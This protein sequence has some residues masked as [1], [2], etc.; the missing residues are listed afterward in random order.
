MR[1][2]RSVIIAGLVLAMILPLKAGFIASD[3]QGTLSK[4]SPDTKIGIIVHMAERP[5]LSAFGKGNYKLKAEYLRDLARRTQKD[6]LAYLSTRGDKVEDIKTFWTMNG[7][8]LKATPDVIREIAKRDDVWAVEKDSK[9]FILGRKTSGKHPDSKSRTVEWNIA[10]IKADSVWEMGYTGQGVILGNL[11]TGVDVTHPALQGKYLGY[12][13]DG[14]NGQT[15]PYDDHGHGTH[16]MGTMVGGDGP[17]PF[18]DDIGI[19]YNAMFVAAKAFN[20]WGSGEE[21]WILACFD[22]FA[23]LVA[24][25][26]INV[27]VVSNSW[28]SS[29]NTALTFWD[30]ILTWRSL[31]IIPVF[32]SGNSGPGSGSAGTPGNFPTVIGVGATDSGDNI[33]GFSSRGPAP[34]QDPWNDSQYWGR[35]DWNLTKPDISAPGVSVR[36][37][38]PG[39]GYDS[40]DGTSMATPHVAA[41]VALMFE[42]N[43][44]LDYETIYNTLL[45]YADHPSQ[46]GS[47]PNNDYG[48][49]RLNAYRAL[50]YTPSANI[51]HDVA[52]VMILAPRGTVAAGQALT[53]MA[54][55]RN[56]GQNTETFDV[57]FEIRDEDLNLVYQSTRTVTDLEPLTMAEVDFDP[58]TPDA[59]IY[60]TMI[61]TSLAGDE[62]SMNDTLRSGFMARLIGTDYLVWDFDPNHSSGPVVDSLLMSLGY[63]GNYKTVASYADSIYQYST[64]WVFVGIFSSNYVIQEGSPEAQAIEDY[65]NMG[66]RVY[67][68]G[69]DVWYYDPQGGGHDFCPTFGINPVEDGSGDLSTVLGVNGTFTTGMSFSYSGENSWIDH[70]D[71]VG[72]ALTIFTNSSPPYN[73][74]VAYDAGPYKTVGFSFELGGLDD[75]A[76]PSTRLELVEAIM[77]FFSGGSGTPD[78]SVT[79]LSFNVNLDAG[80]T[81]DTLLLIANNGD[82]NLFFSINDVQDFLRATVKPVPKPV[83]SHIE[84]A[85]GERDPR[86][87]IAPL[88]GQGGP[89]AFGHLWIDSDE[90]GGPTYEWVDIT[91]SG[92]PLNFGDDDSLTVSLPFSFSFY[93]NAKN[94]VKIASNG[95]LTFGADGSDYSNDPIPDPDDPN[96]LIAVFWDDLN[97]SAS[98]EVY[99]YN[100]EANGRFIVEWYQVPHFYNEGS[101]TFEVILYPDGEM[102]FQYQTMDGDLES[103]TIGIENADA[104][105]GLQVVYNAAYIHDELAIHIS[106]PPD[107]LSENPTS[108][109][110]EPGNTAEIAVSFNATELEPGTHTGTILITSNDPDQHIIEIPV[111]LTVGG[112]SYLPG[113]ANNDGEVNSTDLVYL[114]VYLF[115]G[116]PQPVP[117]YAGDCNGDCDV[118]MADLQYLA[119]YLFAGGPEPIGCPEGRKIPAKVGTSK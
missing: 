88:K 12:F 42:K 41:T 69:G 10:R 72:T 55:F 80:G 86:S 95:Y 104:S 60:H 5:D 107:W 76:S 113:D 23:S 27:R 100:D 66:G 63:A 74:G 40:W 117:Y 106:A 73:C 21:S 79:P 78:I 108:G 30:A 35:P 102:T 61:Y 110:L 9:T 33:A 84:L 25:S 109:M 111:T 71:P 14:V 115:A 75:G 119:N 39:G 28:G 116:G 114:S 50:I 101:Y 118:T 77:N 19:A 112:I 91:S 53:P 103:A 15:S 38:V 29:D 36:S 99:Y 6:L 54:R 2:V 24:D 7:L 46:G 90:P 87:G 62:N 98:G 92:T 49:G 44:Y 52:A 59:G 32:A 82:G 51:D 26:G 34:D 8:A 105:D 11:D 94:S 67:L 65:L 1:G 31:G 83:Y 68:E 96:D 13:F 45:D 43:P 97:P 22:W 4:A 47:Y 81:L 20:S 64:V 57:T 18:E 3:L 56:F 16:T 85:K 70:I 37:S 17:G 93:G 58:F 48:W 89:D